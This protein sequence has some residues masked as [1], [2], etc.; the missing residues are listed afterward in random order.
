MRLRSHSL[1][2]SPP[3]TLPTHSQTQ[4]TLISESTIIPPFTG[5]GN[6]S[7]HQFIRRINEECTRRSAHSDAEKLAI[8]K[9]RV[10]FDQSSLAGKL[11]KSDKFLSLTSYNEFTEALLSHFS[12]H[13]SLGATH[14]LIKVARSLTHLARTT[15]DV[16]KAE[17]TASSLSSELT[18]QLKSSNWFE[19][20]KLSSSNFQRLMS[21]LLFVVQ[22]DPTTFAIASDIEFKEKDFIYDVCKQISEKSPHDLQSQSVS[23]VQ[24]PPTPAAALNDPSCTSPQPSV[25]SHSR[26]RS[27]SRSSYRPQ[28]RQRSHSRSSRNVTCH[29]CG[30]K[31]H[32]A[33]YCRVVLDDHGRAQYNYHAFCSLHNKRGHSLAECRLYQQQLSPSPQ[34]S[35]NASRPSL[36]SHT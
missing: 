17:N 3:D 35:G 19:G 29:R 5:A 2:M 22:L 23:I 27:S 7:V 24:T 4:V 1:R 10:C 16:F 13:S 31:G 6:E 26:A 18:D 28:P 33:Q 30:L 9:S 20:D 34:P 15:S 25:R 12:S 8:L 21:Y 14:S 11:V 32:V 36:N